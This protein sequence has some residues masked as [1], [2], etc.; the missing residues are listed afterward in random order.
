MKKTD[1]TPFFLRPN[2]LPKLPAILLVSIFAV[3]IILIK[4]NQNIGLFFIAFYIS[5]WTVK[6]FESYYYVLRSYIE[7]LDYDKMDMANNELVKENGEHI[8]HV[9]VVPIYTEPYDVIEENVTAIIANDYPH[10][11]NIVVVLATEARA[12]EA[13]SH[14]A[15]IIE[16]FKN[17]PI[18]IFNIVHPDGLPDEG[19]V[20]GAN[21]TY[22]VK[23]YEEMVKCD[24]HNTF[25]STIDTDTKVE[26]NFFSIVT[27][28]FVTTE[29]REQAIY[30][31]TPVYSNN[32]NEG[33]FFARLIA[34]GTT[35]WQL[36]ESQ[37]PEFY[38]NFAVYGQSL[39]CLKKS[40]YWSKTSIV[41][42]GFQYWRS[43]FAW[44]GMFRIV[45]VPA[46]CHMD[47]VDESSLWRTVR[48]QYKQLRRWSWGCTDIEYVLP[49]F[50]KNTKIPFWEKVRKSVYLIQNHLFWAG[51]AFMLFFI[52]Y[53]PGV[54]ESFRNSIAI[55]TVPLASSLMFTILFG[56]VVFP[57]IMSIH[58]M[59]RYT[60]FRKRDYIFNVL[61][62]LV[63]P[64]LTLTLF[65]IPAIESQIRLFLGKRIDFF[66][67]TQ[68]MKRKK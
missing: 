27:Y 61:Q 47:L 19:K 54:F 24:P 29:Y 59:K 38:R 31:Y 33:T 55:L 50:Y 15:K 58:I 28:R 44:D 13:E 53:I 23:K 66:E 45:N 17:S 65:S 67:T 62:W 8:K 57:S 51:G 9:V 63:I 48:S 37:N 52:G 12:P 25:V 14:A 18:E 35:L 34:M 64:A 7:L 49:E 39:E 6:V 11:Q 26:K 5:Y 68:K 41:E 32:W 1:K 2:V 21:I 30:Q 60:K 4:F 10:M 3:P 43:Y 36:F 16:N 20:K 42:D 56:T 46:V 40:D 22:A